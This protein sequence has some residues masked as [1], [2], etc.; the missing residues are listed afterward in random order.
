[1]HDITDAAIVSGDKIH[2]YHGKWPFWRFAGMQEPAS[3]AFSLLNMLFH[4][5]AAMKIKRRIP[6]GHPMRQYYLVFA[7]VSLNA[8]I[9]SSVFHTRDMP[10]TEKLDYFSAALAILYALF[11]TVVRLYHPYPLSTHP[12][13]ASLARSRIH[14]LWATL[15]SLAYVGHVAYLSVLPRFDYA[16]NMAFNLAVG[17]THNVL[18]LLYSFPS[19]LSIFRR[20]PGRPRDY[21]PTYTSKA[22]IFVLLTTAAT[23]L[24][25]FDFPPWRRIMDAHSL[26]H[27]ATAPIAVFWYEFLIE[28]ALDDGWKAGKPE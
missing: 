14:L 10:I 2:Q 20:F 16:Y 13:K 25:L 26:W 12:S 21:R 17:M 1:M 6:L 23:S 3:V 8:W 11:Y 27:L 4:A 7:A 19:S 18:W 9:W 5:Q 15:C 24:E 22:A 28:D